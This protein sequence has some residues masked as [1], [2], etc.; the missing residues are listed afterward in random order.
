MSRTD[1]AA[2]DAFA[3]VR[4]GFLGAAFFLATFFLA[5]GFG[6]AFLAVFFFAAFRV[7]GR[8]REVFFPAAVFFLGSSHVRQLER[9]ASG[10]SDRVIRVCTG[11]QRMGESRIRGDCGTTRG[12][13]SRRPASAARSRCA[14][15]CWG[16]E[17]GR[18]S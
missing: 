12:V 7:E 10:S 11:V 8:L 9:C 13:F 2:C 3:R 18:A 1:S 16:M 6:A 5:A 17:A 14:L 15:R 4:V